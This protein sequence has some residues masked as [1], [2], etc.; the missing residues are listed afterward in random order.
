LAAILW[1]NAYFGSDKHAAATNDAAPPSD[2]PLAQSDRSSA[3]APP[4][5]PAQGTAA[6]PAERAAAPPNVLASRAATPSMSSTPPSPASDRIRLAA[7]EHGA[8]TSAP[9]AA[10][11][12]SPSP[13]DGAPAGPL[14]R[15][16]V[17]LAAD[18]IDVPLTDPAARIVVRR[19]GSLQGPATFTWWTE[20]GT[21]KPGQD[22][23]AVMPHQEVIE[24]G[25]NS[26]SLFI[27]VVGDPTRQQPKSFYVVIN[28]PG[29]GVTLGARTLTMVTIPPSQ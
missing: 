5:S 29:S 12:P 11:L 20:S 18:T 24:E 10:S 6:P 17:E 4:S 3:A 2:A 26:V 9:P 25:K 1:A 14:P 27:P 16:R 7:S 15:S 22:F 13:A 19:R 8:A 28:D 23:I 21:A